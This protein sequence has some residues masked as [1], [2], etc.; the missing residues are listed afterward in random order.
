MLS[1]KIDWEH[2]DIKLK[3]LRDD[4]LSFLI[5]SIAV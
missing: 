3:T 4:S 5:N 1:E 2:L